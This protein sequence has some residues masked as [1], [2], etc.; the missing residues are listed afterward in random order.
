MALTFINIR[1]TVAA[2]ETAYCKTRR[3]AESVVQ[4]APAAGGT[5]TVHYTATDPG[6]WGSDGSGANWELVG[7]FTALE[8]IHFTTPIAGARVAAADEDVTV[9]VL[10][11]R[12]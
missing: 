3:D 10:G 12:P 11:G 6:Q 7:A 9:D 1:G 5:A 2:G 8:T 4:V